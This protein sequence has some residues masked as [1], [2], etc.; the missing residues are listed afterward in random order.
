M[1]NYKIH[2]LTVQALLLS[3]ILAIALLQSDGHSQAFI[4]AFNVDR[5]SPS[6]LN[7]ETSDLPALKA[8]KAFQVLRDPLASLVKREPSVLPESLV[9]LDALVLVES[10]VTL[11]RE[12]LLENKDPKVLFYW[13]TLCNFGMNG[14]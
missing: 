8:S 10:V 3:F 13:L 11:E 9:H 4:H 14:D 12:D 7:R 5:S 2:S 1:I 6:C